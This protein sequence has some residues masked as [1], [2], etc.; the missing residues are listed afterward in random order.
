MAYDCFLSYASQ[1]LAH[2]EAVHARL[3]A[4]GFKVWFDKARLQPGYD[5]HKEIEEGCETSRVI[6]PLLTP[7]WKQ[8]EWTRYE[9]YG[10][11]SVIPLLVDGEWPEVSTPPLT[12]FQNLCL[13]LA[14]ATEPDWQRLFDSIREFCAREAPQK[15]QRVH[16][17]RYHPAKHFVGREK[18]LDEIHEKLFV[19][20]TAALTQGHVQAIAAMGGVGKTT[21]ARQYAEK[22]WRCYPQ[23][24]WADCRLGLETEFAA[25]HDTLRQES[26]YSG[27]STKDKAGWVRFELSQ[28]AN[29]PRRLLILDN[30]DDEESVL[31]WIPKT[32][33]CHTLITSRFTGWS[34]GIET[35]RVWVLDPE[36]ARELLLRRSG[37]ADTPAERGA[38]D[39]LAEK[40]EYLPLAL[41]QAAAYVGAQPPGWGFAEYLRLYETNERA[42]LTK[43]TPGATEYSDSVYLTW[44]ATIDKLPQGSRAMLRLHAFVAATP[45]PLDLY[46][47]GAATVVEEARAAG[48]AGAAADAD[49]VGARELAVRDW[50][51]A[52][53]SYSMVTVQTSGSF[54]VHSL[55]QAVQRHEL[56]AGRVRTLRRM[57]DLMVANTAWPS[58][59]RESRERWD[60]LLAHAEDLCESAQVLGVERNPDLVEKVALANWR[61]GDYGKAVLWQREGLEATERLLGKEHPETLTSVNNLALLLMDQGDYEPV[62]PL[63]RRALEARERVLG[64]EHPDTLT[65]VNNLAVWFKYK[66]DYA[67]AE[68]LYRRALEARERVLG[69]DHPDTLASVNNLAMLFD[70]QGDYAQAESLLRRALEAQERVLG[71]E[72]PDTLNSVNN[73]AGL[74]DSQGD[75]GKAEPLFRRALKGKDRVLGENHPDTLVTLQNLTDLLSKA[76][77][78]DESAALRREYITRTKGA[79]VSAAPLAFRELALECYRDGDYSRAEQ[80]LRRIVEQGFELCSTHCH[81]ARVLL[82]M[83]RDK[84]ALA[85]VNLAWE[86]RAEGPLY[87]PQRLHFLRA[88]FGLLDGTAP[89]EALKDL[90][91]EL[92]RPDAMQEWDLRRLLD[93]LKPRLTP[94]ASELLEALSAAINDRATIKNLETLPAWQAIC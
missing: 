5:W 37:R 17:L 30:A 45:F 20:P 93:H 43:K 68:P 51:A 64:K 65:S 32:G 69:K 79:E 44:R 91:R 60:M 3:T 1:D 61:R 29:R 53:A 55:V 35:Y 7:R 38:C 85:E 46:I 34:S 14:S 48:E 47:A 33:N 54:S 90:K 56:G 78:S 26:V 16:R 75:Y 18:D 22:F 62:G 9:T 31:E 73:L 8:S 21:L 39:A 94:E 83:D 92:L 86:N 66:G 15:E 67:Q 36:P 87:V 10:A 41:E 40:L 28:S 24:F 52:L 88:L 12:V 82:L 4:A 49:L 19:N 71:K 6:L 23:M 50:F 63:Y 80:L 81:L 11:E 77:R 2:A 84:E 59:E 42:F 57:T 70:G 58:W 89:T 13:P 76:G 25:I 72:H 74:L 27:L